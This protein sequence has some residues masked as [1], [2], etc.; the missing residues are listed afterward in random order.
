MIKIHPKNH[1]CKGNSR[2][3]PKKII[4]FMYP[5]LSQEVFDRLSPKLQVCT[6]IFIYFKTKEKEHNALI[7]D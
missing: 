1:I 7:Q 4:K 2:T 6:D 5:S 3:I